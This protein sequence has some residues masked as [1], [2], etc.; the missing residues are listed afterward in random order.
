MNENSHNS[1][2]Y[3]RYVAE[4][5]PLDFW[6]DDRSKRGFIPVRFQSSIS[7]AKPIFGLGQ[8]IVPSKTFVEKFSNFIGVIVEPLNNNFN[9]LAWSGFT[10]LSKLGEDYDEFYPD[11]KAIYF[12]ENWNFLLSNF[13]DDEYYRVK[14]LPDETLFEINRKS[15]EEFV[16][17]KD[18]KNNNEILMNNDGIKITDTFSNFIETK[19]EGITIQDNFGNSIKMTSSGISI[20]DKFGHILDLGSSGTKVDGDYITLKPFVDWVLNSAPNWGIGNF[21]APVPIFPGNLASLN[22]GVAPGQNF[23]SNKP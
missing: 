3:T 21:G 17:I 11:H 7:Y 9:E 5:A 15:G 12:D 23:V 8:F 16:Q 1:K 19:S 6:V 2:N 4:F 18:G 22:I 20:E 14:Y 10:Y 13:K